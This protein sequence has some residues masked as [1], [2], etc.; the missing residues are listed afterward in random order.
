MIFGEMAG[1]S[2]SFFRRLGVNSSNFVLRARLFIQAFC[3]LAFWAGGGM[4]R[5]LLYNLD[6][7]PLFL[8]DRLIETLLLVA[9]LVFAD[10][11][12]SMFFCHFYYRRTKGQ[13]PI[14]A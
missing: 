2:F 8:N 6:L 12:A 5:E 14:K 4:I 7:K 9:I 10:T 13:S 11:F 3:V 1:Q